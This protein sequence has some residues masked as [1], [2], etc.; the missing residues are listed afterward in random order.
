[1]TVAGRWTGLLGP[2]AVTLL[3]LFGGA[4]A[5]SKNFVNSSMPEMRPTFVVNFDMAT[6]ICQHSENPA[7]LHLHEISVLCDGKDDCYKNPAMH[8]ESFP[9]C[10]Q[11]CNSTCNYRGACLYDGQKAQCYCNSGFS[12]PTCEI[13]DKNECLHKPCHWLAHCQNTLGS[14]ECACF[15]G[16]HGD[17]YQC[18]DIDECSTSLHN[19]PENSKCV[20][21]PGTYF[22]NC[23][24]GFA[25]KGLPLEKCA[26]INECELNLHNCEKHQMCQNKVG[27][28]TCVHRCSV[29]YQF[30]D[31]ECVDID[32]C[33]LEDFCDRRAE[34]TNT[35]GG[36][37]CKCDEGLTGDGKHCSPITDCSQNEEICDR[38]AFCI[39]SLKLCLCQTG[40]VGDGITCNDVNECLSMENA[41][42]DQKGDRCVNIKG[43]YVCCEENV[44]DG[45]CIQD[46]GAFC[47]GGCGL[48]AICFNQTCQCMEGFV[49]D[50]HTRCVDVN[51]CELNEMC[52]GVGQWCVNTIGGHICCSPDSKEPECQGLHV[53][54]THDGQ[55]M[56]QYNNS[57]GDVIIQQV[58]FSS[59]NDSGGAIITR[60]GFLKFGPVSPSLN[61]NRR[62]G[63]EIAGRP[64]D[65]KQSATNNRNEEAF[66]AASL[67]ETATGEVISQITH[68]VNSFA[69][70]VRTIYHKSGLIFNPTII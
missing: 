68:E 8:D 20:N 15:P 40:Y 39:K 63:L 59:R 26:D 55:I 45:Q 5:I 70:F 31:G 62:N 32:E 48:H 64:H 13:V 57:V 10:E 9:Y 69:F 49:G 42:K 33:R 6:V 60:R 21:L 25:P 16:F 35:P 30:V 7:D 52:A 28:F 36:Y 11:K 23:T 43:G 41:C 53:F 19:C 34:C 66:L 4:R 1:M 24:E 54:K 29:G 22:C 37:Q 46:H 61:V 12:G 50:P 47:A 65:S 44:D 67:N 2:L 17:G 38:H 3:L 27:G 58:G 14:Y 18:A 51:E 56:L